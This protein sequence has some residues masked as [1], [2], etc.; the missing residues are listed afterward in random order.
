MTG[1]ATADDRAGTRQ[2]AFGQAH[3]LSVVDRLGRWL[4]SR[5]VRAAVGPVPGRAVIDIGCGYHA[6]LAVRLF[7][8]ARELVL[9]DV[10]LDPAL[11]ER[12]GTRLVEGYLPDAL[13]TVASASIDVVLCNNVLEHLWE[14][15]L[16]LHEIRRVLRP[17]GTAV[18]NVP[19]WWGKRAL[20]FAAFRVGVAPAAEMDDHKCYYD[21]RDLWPLLVKAGFRPSRIRCRR[22][23]FGLNTLAICRR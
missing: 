9:V 16:T 2:L 3:R 5:R 4:S 18:V 14:P 12:P 8:A 17:G 21:P 20:E 22:H 23:K 7:A 6:D 11:A 19:T 10:S 1:A 13:S 15:E